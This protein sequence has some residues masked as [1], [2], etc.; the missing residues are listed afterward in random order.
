MLLVG[1]A[2]AA[3]HLAEIIRV[4]DIADLGPAGPNEEVVQ[5]DLSDAAAMMEPTKDCD[6]ILLLV[7]L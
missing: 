6:G 2:V 4:S 1:N 3:G 7:R 5:C